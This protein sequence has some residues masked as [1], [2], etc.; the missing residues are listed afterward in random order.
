MRYEP[1]GGVSV[2]EEGLGAPNG[3]A[4]LPDGSL[5]TCEH[6]RRRIRR[7]AAD[8][9]ISTFADRWAG[10]RLNSPNDLVVGPDGS[11]WFT[12]PRYG[13]P[14]GRSD[15]GG[16]YVFR[17]A[18][19]DRLPR[20]VVTEL[21]R[22]NGIGLSPDGRTL[23]VA[24]SGRPRALFAFPLAADGTVGEGRVLHR[25]EV[26]VPDG[27][28]VDEDGRIFLACGDGVRVLDPDGRPILLIPS[29][30]PLTNVAFGGPEGRILYCT[31]RSALFAVG[32]LASGDR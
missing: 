27:L 4:L 23:Y 12:D 8:G 21:D 30:E 10:G 19:G 26:G 16:D 15:Y 3:N 17:L 18:P 1:G 6:D 28:A 2:F 29:P 20:P 7:R 31:G 14:D 25:A 22:P 9:T 11:V 13:R 24:D 5:L 32:L